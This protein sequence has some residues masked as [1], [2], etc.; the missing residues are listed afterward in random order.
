MEQKMY[1]FPEIEQFRNVIQQVNHRT[2]YVGK[3]EDGDPIYDE[4]PVEM[5][6]LKFRGTVKLHGTNAAIV[7]TWDMLKFEYVMH[8]QS[9]KNII[10]PMSDNAGFAAFAHNQYRDSFKDYERG[11]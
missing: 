10:T 2:R 9:R 7:Y 11:W 4:G 5:P 1:K 6:T 8:A 3:T